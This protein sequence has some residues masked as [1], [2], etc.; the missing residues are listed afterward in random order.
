MN[1]CVCTPTQ[2]HT[3]HADMGT[4]ECAHAHRDMC[5]HGGG[6]GDGDREDLR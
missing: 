5:A 1:A 6:R 3:H 2:L 4:R